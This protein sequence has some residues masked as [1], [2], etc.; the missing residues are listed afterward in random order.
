ME[1]R[2]YKG[3]RVVWV[4]ECKSCLHR[5]VCPMKH[6]LYWL[7]ELEKEGCEF[8]NPTKNTESISSDTSLPD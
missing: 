6:P 3:Q 2:K 1:F 8:Y 5:D 4:A 7:I